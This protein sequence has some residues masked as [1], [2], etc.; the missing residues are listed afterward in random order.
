MAVDVESSNLFYLIKY[1]F[2]LEFFQ[3]SFS[4][5]YGRLP[6]WLWIDSKAYLQEQHDANLAYD[7]ED[8]SLRWRKYQR[9]TPNNNRWRK[10]FQGERR[11]HPRTEQN[12]SPRDWQ[13]NARLTTEL[14]GQRVQSTIR[15]TSSI[16]SYAASNIYYLQPGRLPR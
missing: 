7:Q 14:R 13:Q 9:T 15:P 8:F 10:A 12:D 4:C 2:F 5:Y 6:H 3:I 1:F 11:R 16:L